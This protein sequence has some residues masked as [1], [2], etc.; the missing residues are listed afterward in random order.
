MKNTKTQ[1]KGI[2]SEVEK[3]IKYNKMFWLKRLKTNFDRRKDI[4]MLRFHN[5]VFKWDKQILIDDY[6]IN[7]I[8]DFMRK[9][10]EYTTEEMLENKRRFDERE[11]TEDVG[12]D[13]FINPYFTN[14]WFKEERKQ[15]TKCLNKILS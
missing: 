5:E 15:L 2:M 11:T 14:Q 3:E 4:N 9:G 8:N 13:G 6:T 1:T 7:H 12:R 10:Y